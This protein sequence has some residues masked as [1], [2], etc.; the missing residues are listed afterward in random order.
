MTDDRGQKR[1]ASIIRHRTSVIS[2]YKDCMR[3][4]IIIPTYNERGT[5]GE[6]IEALESEFKNISQHTMGILVVDG[7]SPDGTA[8][9]ARELA[10]KYG[11][12]NVLVEKEKRGLGM[13]YILGMKHAT[14]VLKVDAYVEFDGD[15]QHD[16]RDIKRLVTELDNGYDYVIGSRYVAGGAVPRGWG[17][18]R[19]MLS[20]LGGLFARLVLFLSVKDPT[21]GLK[22]TRVARFV[23]KLPL[24]ED[25]ILSKRY[26]YKI[27]LL[28]AMI[29]LGAKVKEV[30]I[31]F[32]ERGG[33]VSKAAVKDIFDSLMV[34]LKLRFGIGL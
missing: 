31:N 17:L 5:I 34:V 3:I 20:R 24:S 23:S 30:P 19:K 16:P 15:F 14:E 9:L 18:Y 28:Y 2:H 4:I 26:A 7:N 29:K 8:D 27:H 11:N 22:L 13:A 21:S 12:I 33:G 1:L 25:K 10:K 6:L 32:L